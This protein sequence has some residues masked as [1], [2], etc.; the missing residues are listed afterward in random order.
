[1]ERN[2]EEAKGLEIIMNETNMLW[3]QYLLQ[4]IFVLFLLF[5][6]FFCQDAKIHQKKT[7]H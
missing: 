4:V 7:N 1:V 6:T 5:G 3:A 2:E